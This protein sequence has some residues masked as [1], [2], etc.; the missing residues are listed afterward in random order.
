MGFLI[1]EQ[2]GAKTEW[3][4]KNYYRL[5][6]EKLNEFVSQQPSTT[7]KVTTKA[8]KQAKVTFDHVVEIVKKPF[9]AKEPLPRAKIESPAITFSGTSEATIKIT[10]EQ[11]HALTFEMKY[12][13]KTLRQQRVDIA[14]TDQP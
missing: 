5:D 7:K 8:V 14:T 11:I 3:T 12:F 2:L 6:Y 10:P 1:V 9:T 13:F 4:Q